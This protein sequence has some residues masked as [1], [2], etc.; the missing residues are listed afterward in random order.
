[1][2]MYAIYFMVVKLTIFRL[3]SYVCSKDRLLVLIE[4]PH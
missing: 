3:F 4:L 1:M 2:H